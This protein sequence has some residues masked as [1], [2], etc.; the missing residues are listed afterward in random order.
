ML[1]IIMI[2]III[3][4]FPLS[5]SSWENK[6]SSS[7]TLTIYQIAQCHI[8]EKHNLNRAR[9]SYC[10]YLSYIRSKSRVIRG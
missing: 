2:M 6:A 1:M 8:L 10:K 3:H 9:I 7:E 4:R 5:P